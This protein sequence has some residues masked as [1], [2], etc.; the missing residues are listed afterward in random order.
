MEKS[1]H[2]QPAVNFL[3]GDPLAGF[4]IL[5]EL[6]RGGE[7]QVY[8]AQRSADGLQFAL[9]VSSQAFREATILERLN[10]PGIVPLHSWQELETCDVLV[11]KHLTGPSLADRLNPS[12]P[13]A[14]EIPKGSGKRRRFACQILLELANAVEHVHSKG[15]W[16]LDIKPENILFDENNRP[17]LIDF[18]VA[19]VAQDKIETSSKVGGTLA[20]MSPEQLTELSGTPSDNGKVDSRADIYALGAVF[21][22]LLTGQQLFP[23]LD[24][25]QGVV[26]SAREALGERLRPDRLRSQIGKLPPRERA[27]V[28]RCLAPLKQNTVGP[29]RYPS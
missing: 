27:I 10:H 6:G 28:T 18:S 9:K 14:S 26:E 23:L 25:N 5:H 22:E 8:L 21:Y 16:H 15:I 4:R 20:Y 3:P 29:V 11:L 2:S 24:T 1:H 13:S 19:R 12:H 17:V 7:S